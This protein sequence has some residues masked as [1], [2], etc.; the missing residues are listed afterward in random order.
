MNMRKQLTLLEI[1]SYGFVISIFVFGFV[2]LLTIEE[3]VTSPVYYH[4]SK[5]VIAD[6]NNVKIG[7]LENGD[8]YDVVSQFNSTAL[9]LETKIPDHTFTIVPLSFDDAYTKVNNDE[10]DFLIVNS[11]LYI[12]L[13]VTTD[14]NRIATMKNRTLDVATTSYGS[15]VFTSKDSGITDYEAI[16]GKDFAAV[17]ERSFGGWQM[18]LKDFRDYQ[19]DID[20]FN[21]INYLGSHTEVVSNVIDGTYDVGTVRTGVL[22]KM[23]NDGIIDLND[24]RVLSPNNIGFDLLLSS[25]LYPE[26]PIAK[27]PHISEELGQEVA[28]ALFSIE[29]TDAAAID[30]GISGWIVPLNYQD[31]HTT[32]RLIKAAPYEDYGVV[33]FHNSVYYNRFFIMGILGALFSVITVSFWLKHT[34]D[35]M[36]QLTKHSK[37]MEQVANEANEAKGEFL[38]NMSHEIRTPMS[39]I[40]GLSSLLESTEL[41]PRQEDYNNKLKSSAVN[42]LGIIENILDYSKIDAKQM[43]VEQI[44]FDMNDVLYNLSNVVTL[45]ASEKNIEVLYD[46][47]ASLP[48]KYIGDPLRIGQ[49]LI[50]LIAN[51]IKFTEKGQVVLRISLIDEKVLFE[52]IDSGIGMTKEQIDNIL[53]PFTQADSSFSRKYGGTGLGL[54][55]TNRLINLM[56]GEMEISSTINEGSTFRF[57]LPLQATVEEH[58]VQ[59]LDKP[60]KVLIV[61]DNSVSLNILDKVCTSF[62]LETKT[63]STPFDAIDILENKNFTPDLLILDYVMPT[64]NGVDLL[65]TLKAKKLLKKASSVLMVSA[66]GKEDIV[67]KAKDAGVS[68]FLD[69]P[70][71]PTAFY[72]TIEAV[73]KGK[74][75]KPKK[76]KMTG[77][78]VT[79]VKPGTHILLAEDNKINQ[80]I[81]TEILRKEGFEVTV[82][83]D[84]VELIKLINEDAFDYKLILMDIQMP[85][86]NGREATIA[87]RKRTDKYRRIPIIAMTAH[88]LE[89]EKKKSIEAGMNDFLTKPLDVEKLFKAI[90]KYV[91]LVS[92]SV[93]NN[94]TDGIALDFIDTKAGL[95]NLSGDEGFYLEI[96]YTYLE[97]YKEYAGTLEHLFNNGELD[98]ILIEIHTIKGL[99]ATIGALTLHEHA[100]IL[101]E[102]LK[103]GITNVEQFTLFLNAHKTLISNL[104]AY[105]KANPFR[106]K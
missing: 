92:V 34:R 87:I 60:K 72:K 15:V 37:E 74:V 106:N 66:F 41:S 54:T 19:I 13:V 71:N 97:D 6:P 29:E 59:T 98:D 47:D 7:V 82:A 53:K 70:I 100:I 23:A 96:L 102:E 12:D 88:A 58:I 85:N 44:E 103:D 18:T 28:K 30:S 89:A 20:E 27:T 93:S 83:A 79:L 5:E 105:F 75:T 81:V 45:K 39:A 2:Y 80:A 68:E 49:V 1:L 8:F 64:M 94:T 21:S 48:T 65:K 46:I 40:I 36:V 4:G 101:E 55:I 99:A 67:E 42:L 11:S 32:L 38:A 24:V 78:K 76:R 57:A 61:D 33:S 104:D 52:I 91:K 84:G 16:Y 22:E 73:I 90:S 51:A 17:N 95:K 56:G 69:K 25:Q 50:N 14:V 26:W 3:E 10:V 43:Q 62:G 63:T 9:Y 31:V 35:T 86:M 77:N